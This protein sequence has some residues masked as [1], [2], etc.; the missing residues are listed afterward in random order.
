MNVKTKSWVSC[1]LHDLGRHVGSELRR[2]RSRLAQTIAIRKE[3]RLVEGRD[4][5]T[6]NTDSK[7]CNPF[8]GEIHSSN[9]LLER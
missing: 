4:S 3:A 2:Y 7:L 9:L 6:E 1:S 5:T 8:R